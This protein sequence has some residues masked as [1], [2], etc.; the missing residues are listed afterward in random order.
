MSEERLQSIER[1]IERNCEAIENIRTNHLEH[2]KRDT[3]T[4]KG[5]MVEVKTDLKWLKK[6]YWIVVSASVGSLIAALI[7][8]I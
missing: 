7:N 6:T 8:L 2:L 4:L 1:S 3:D 5:D